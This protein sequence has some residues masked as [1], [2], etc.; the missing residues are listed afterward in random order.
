M[1]KGS[2]VSSNYIADDGYN[3][4]FYVA[5]EPGIHGS[6]RGT[7]RPASKPARSKHTQRCE[8][9]TDE[10]ADKATAEEVAPRILTW[11]EVD[12]D[13]Q[14]R[15]ITPETVLGIKPALFQILTGMVMGYVPTDLDPTW[16]KE[17]QDA[18]RAAIKELKDARAA[19]D[20]QEQAETKN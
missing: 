6:I 2:P 17:E 14:P 1:F 11:S 5:P 8:K 9:L 12:K 7:F 19:R 3:E 20:V 13:G 10:E 4:K 18:Y 15:P 16:P